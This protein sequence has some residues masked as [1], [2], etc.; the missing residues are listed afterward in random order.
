MNQANAQRI[1]HALGREGFEIA[2]IHNRLTCSK[3]CSTDVEVW[4]A[5][6]DA[7]DIMLALKSQRY[8]EWIS[9]GYDPSLADSVFDAEAPEATCPACGTVFLPKLGKCPDCGLCF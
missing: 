6:A 4:A 1:K 5:K 2:V 7:E 9:N 8:S 3:G